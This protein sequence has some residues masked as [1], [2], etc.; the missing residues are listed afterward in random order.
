L[1]V[2]PLSLEESTVVDNISGFRNCENVKAANVRK[3]RQPLAP[4]HG[5]CFYESGERVE[6][7]SDLVRV[8]ESISGLPPSVSYGHVVLEPGE[9]RC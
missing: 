2:E 3:R 4:G 1:P 9:R 7:S 8:F 5:C 6:D